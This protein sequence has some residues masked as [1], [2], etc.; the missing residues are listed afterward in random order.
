MVGG[1]S[2]RIIPKTPIMLRYRALRKMSQAER[3]AE[4]KRLVAQPE[5]LAA[6][7]AASV[8]HFTSYSNLTDP[9]Y[10]DPFYQNPFYPDPFYPERRT[11]EYA[12][13]VKSTN[14]V[15]LP[16][17]AQKR[18]V[19][20]DA[21]TRLLAHDAGTTVAA[22]PASS[23]AADYVDREL[24]VH[25]TT[26]PAEWEDGTR[27]V[28]GLRLDVLLA[29]AADRTPIVAELKLPG[30]MDPFFALIQALACAAHL[31]TT[32]QYERMRKQL[33]GGRFP[34]LPGAPRVDAWVLFKDPDGHTPGQPP[35]GRYMSDLKTAAEALAPAL[36][37]HE[38][39]KASVRRIAGLGITVDAAEAVT[40]DVRWAWESGSA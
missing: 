35:R 27:N 24:L 37:T 22:V 16:L 14:D 29:D 36:L 18:L 28:G 4:A 34:E 9:F 7:F 6:E 40:A 1:M 15:V 2:K 11:P 13:E 12:A 17:E 30:D 26:S 31:A 3:L 25:R 8:A 38:G 5:D 20:I 33:P 32:N 10:P 21:P 19:P 39:I 23:L